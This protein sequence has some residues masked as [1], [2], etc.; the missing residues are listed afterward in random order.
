M[1]SILKGEFRAQ[2]TNSNSLFIALIQ[3]NNYSQKLHGI[4]LQIEDYTEKATLR[5]LDSIH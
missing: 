1:S 2:Y 4:S 5:K 3:V